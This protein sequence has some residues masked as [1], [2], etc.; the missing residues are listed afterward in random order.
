MQLQPGDCLFFIVRLV[1]WRDG[2]FSGPPGF[3][4]TGFLEIEQVFS[5]I[6][7]RPDL[8]SLERI[9]NNAHVRRGLADPAGWDG[10]WV[11]AG[12]P[13]SQRF[14]YAVPFT[15]AFADATMLDAAGQPWRWDQRSALQVTGSYTRSCRCILSAANDPDGSRRNAWWSHVRA[16]NP[17][18]SIT[19]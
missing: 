3:Y 4:L 1:P 8:S 14:R 2:R 17:S 5:G 11:F 7:A 18:L 19:A 6:S 15:R 12:T 13:R 9:A 16:F 10:F